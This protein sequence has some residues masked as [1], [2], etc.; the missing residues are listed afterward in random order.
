VKLLLGLVSF[1]PP[2]RLAAI[3]NVG[4]DFT[5]LGLH[6]S[7]DLDTVM[8]TLAGQ[9]NTDTGWGRSEESWQFMKG[10]REFGAETWFNLG[11]RDL[12]T[13]ICR[14]EWLREG[15]TLSEVTTR[16]CRRLGVT[17]DV[18]PATDD[19]LRTI[20]ETSQGTLAFQHYFV[21]EQCRPSVEAIHFEG[22]GEARPSPGAETWLSKRD[23]GAVIICPSNPYLSVDPILAVPRIKELLGALDAPIIAIS[24]LIAGQAV[25][26]PTAKIMRELGLPLT[27]SAIARHYAGIVQGFVLDDRDETEAEIIEAMG[28]ATL[29]TNIL[30]LDDESKIRLAH[31]VVAFAET[32]SPDSA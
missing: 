17:H 24:P 21:R 13:H 2:D 15:A 3:T 5:H 9:V 27:A 20:I 11:D 16:L 23:L 10:L 18:V 26:G 22:A 8:Y 32:L 14:S 29:R 28:I 30:M 19:R 12:A 4:D 25:K 31:E 6:I 7:P 1:L